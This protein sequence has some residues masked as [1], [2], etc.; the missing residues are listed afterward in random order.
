VL[1][2]HCVC[3]ASAGT[4][5]ACSQHRLTWERPPGVVCLAVFQ[6]A[7]MQLLLYLT[8]AVLVL[9]SAY[10][11]PPTLCLGMARPSAVPYPLLG[12]NTLVLSDVVCVAPNEQGHPCLMVRQAQG[13]ARARRGFGACGTGC[14]ASSGLLLCRRSAIGLT[15]FLQKHALGS[16]MM[17]HQAHNTKCL[18]PSSPTA[19]PPTPTPHLT[20]GTDCF[21]Q[22]N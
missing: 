21:P 1:L 17:L 3:D 18:L 7:I 2:Y 20:L 5:A 10:C 12:E 11:P 9:P 16:G 4:G 6:R 22:H 8:E 13:R 14:L 15:L 19:V